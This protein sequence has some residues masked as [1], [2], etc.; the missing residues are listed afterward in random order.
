[1]HFTHMHA[2]YTACS[3]YTL[4]DDQRCGV[5]TCKAESLGCELGAELF[6]SR[7]IMP[8]H[9]VISVAVV[10]YRVGGGGVM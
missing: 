4:T 2:Y 6:I 7:L 10:S 1:M 3:H 5:L 8:M 9:M